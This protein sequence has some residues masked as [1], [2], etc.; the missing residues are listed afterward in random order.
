MKRH[1]GL[2]PLTHDHHHALAQ[3][4]RLRVAATGDGDLLKQAKEFLR[5]FQ[6][7]TIDHFRQEEETLFPFAVDDERAKPL[8][9]RVVLEHLQLH[10]LV[11]RLRAE[12]EGGQPTQDTAIQVARAL[13]SHVRLEETQVFPLLEEILPPKRLGDIGLALR[14]RARKGADLV[15]GYRANEE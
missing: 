3:A 13:E 5:F 11:G 10:A 4:R 7:E 8:L 2:I 15:V 14:S 12:I 6:K 9:G 1:Q